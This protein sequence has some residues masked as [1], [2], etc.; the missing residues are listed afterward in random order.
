MDLWTVWGRVPD[1]Y[2]DALEIEKLREQ[3]EEGTDPNFRGPGGTTAL[4]RAATFGALESLRFLLERGADVGALDDEGQTAACRAVQI[5]GYVEIAPFEDELVRPEAALE[6]LRVLHEYGADLAVRDELGRSLVDLAR[7]QDVIDYV[8]D[9]TDAEVL[10]ASGGE[11]ER[12]RAHRSRTSGLRSDRSRGPYRPRG[13]GCEDFAQSYEDGLTVARVLGVVAAEPR[14]RG[15]LGELGD[16][17]DARASLAAKTSSPFVLVVRATGTEAFW[18][19]THDSVGALPGGRVASRVIEALGSAGLEPL[20]LRLDG[21]RY[22]LD[23][24]GIVG[25]A[26][27]CEALEAQGLWV[28]AIRPG[29]VVGPHRRTSGIA[30]ELIGYRADEIDLALFVK[31]V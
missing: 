15:A 25:F 19:Y 3:W 31:V 14:V 23:P 22:T 26:P 11:T 2:A 1:W 21:D 24:G 13:A 12:E 27:V 7:T 8:V 20:D 29:L 10:A 16:V 17:L 4:H 30:V 28:P 5:S 9:H 18:L 6:A